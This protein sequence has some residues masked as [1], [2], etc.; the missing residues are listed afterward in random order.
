M[1]G[2]LAWSLLAGVQPCR[3]AGTRI[4]L[5]PAPDL[6]AA[7][8]P[9][10]PLPPAPQRAPA[11]L[12]QREDAARQCQPHLQGRGRTRSARRVAAGGL[13]KAARMHCACL[14]PAPL[15]PAPTS[16]MLAS[17]SVPSGSRCSLSVPR[18]MPRMPPAGAG[19]A[20]SAAE[21]GGRGGQP[22]ACG[23]VV[24]GWG[25]GAARR[26]AGSGQAGRTRNVQRGRQRAGGVLVLGDVVCGAGGRAKRGCEGAPAT[27]GGALPRPGAFSLQ[28]DSAS[29]AQGIRRHTAL[30]PQQP[31]S[32]RSSR[33]SSLHAPQKRMAST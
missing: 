24:R 21:R 33:S 17:G 14:P 6:G 16:S 31:H 4:R 8:R 20:V 32:R 11:H 27:A 10:P 9:W 15:S 29:R 7:C 2:W 1:A 23:G 19:E 13:P 12:R 30:P 3:H 18:S 28:P 25:A 5:L 26:A 22:A